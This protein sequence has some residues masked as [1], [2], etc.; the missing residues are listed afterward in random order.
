MVNTEGKLSRRSDGLDGN[1]H[2]CTCGAWAYA[3]IA[4]GTCAT[5]RGEDH[6]VR[7]TD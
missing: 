5:L 6:G 4:C 7:A 1:I 2:R 3:G